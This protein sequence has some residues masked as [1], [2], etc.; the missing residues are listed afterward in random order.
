[1]LPVL[2]RP[3]SSTPARPGSSRSSAGIAAVLTGEPLP[4]PP[5]EVAWRL[6]E[7]AIHQELSRFRYCTRL[8]RRGRRARRGRARGRA[9]AARRLAPRR[10]R[11]ERAKVH[12]HT[13]DPGRALSLGVARGTIAGVE[14]ANM[15]EQ[16]REREER[17]LHAVPSAAQATRGVAVASGPATGGS[18]RASARAVVDGGR[19]MNPSTAELLA[20]V[21]A[22]RGAG[23]GHPAERPQR[24]DGRRARGRERVEAGAGGADASRCRPG[25]RRWSRSTRRASRGENAAR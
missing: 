2:T 25:S 3:A 9:R 12:V 16:T 20:A 18:S 8:R 21:E 5:A 6:D 19:T 1:M 13:D 23:G 22:D 4:E 7:D 10:R 15:H 17:L 11:P 24:P 14:I